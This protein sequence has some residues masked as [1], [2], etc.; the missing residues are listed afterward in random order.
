MQRVEAKL[1]AVLQENAELKAALAHGK[2]NG[3]N[4]K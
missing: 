1:Q 3:M 4:G 2:I